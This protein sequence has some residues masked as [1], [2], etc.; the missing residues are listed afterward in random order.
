[1]K[2]LQ[3][4]HIKQSE[5]TSC[6]AAT[7]A[8]VCQYFGIDKTEKEIW[9]YLKTPRTS[10]QGDFFIDSKKSLEKL[11]KLGLYYI[12]G[13]SYWGFEESFQ[14][15]EQFLKLG[16]PVEV[17]QQGYPD[18][19]L[20][21]MRI[22]VGLDKDYVYVND[23]EKDKGGTKMRRQEFY[24]AWE[25]SGEEVTGGILKVVFPKNKTL[26][27]GKLLLDDLDTNYKNLEVVPS[28]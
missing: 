14:P 10:V 18:P 15:I 6:G 27:I 26:K 19:T 21:H 16:L 4:P 17:I 11:G 1:M 13:R 7:I 2:L 8:M 3:V 20:G 24:D 12:V 25:E 22:V 28:S 23:P 9:D 5:P